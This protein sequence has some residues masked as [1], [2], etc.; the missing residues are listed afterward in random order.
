[1][2]EL[3][4]K[5]KEKLNEI[6]L[7][8]HQEE[9]QNKT[10][11]SC[12]RSSGRR[13]AHLCPDKVLSSFTLMNSALTSLL[14]QILCSSS[15]FRSIWDLEL[16]LKPYLALSCLCDKFSQSSSGS[17]NGDPMI[18]KADIP[19]I[20]LCMSALLSVKL[21]NNVSFMY[22]P[23]MQPWIG[24]QR[25]KQEPLA[26]VSVEV[27]CSI[28]NNKKSV[29]PTTLYHTVLQSFCTPFF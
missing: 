28:N 23:E 5:N 4:L 22:S 18:E 29:I 10:G 21:H 24:F 17:L 6:I 13:R 15:N 1:M 20:L 2:F 14:W 8:D 3:G 27:G 26:S 12:D 9:K 11:L 7:K 16:H 25:P 19:S